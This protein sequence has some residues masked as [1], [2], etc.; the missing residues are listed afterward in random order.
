[1]SSAGLP[2]VASAPADLPLDGALRGAVRGR[3]LRPASVVLGAVLVA[4]VALRVAEVQLPPAVQL[5]PFALSLVVFGLPHGALDHLV[6]V[7]MRATARAPLSVFVVVVA[8]LVL[9]SA[10]AV[11]WWAAPLVGFAG[12]I[13]LT[14]FHWG[15]GD[16]WVRQSVET[17][18]ASVPLAVGTVVVRGG[19]PMLVPFVT[20]PAVY[21]QV[22]LDTAGVVRH[23]PPGDVAAVFQPTVRVAV[24]VVF[25]ATVLLTVL[26][27]ACSARAHPAQRRAFGRDLGA[28]LFLVAF[29]AVVPA[30]LAVGLYFCLWHALRHIVRL[31]LLDPASASDLRAG[32][33]VRPFLRFARDAWPV[34]AIAT[35]MLVALALLRRGEGSPLGVYLA[36]IAALT[37]PHVAVVAWMDRRQ[38]VWGVRRHRREA[39][40]VEG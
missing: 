24:G 20:Q 38:G 9:G 7:R 21:R 30:V 12:F 14:W 35:A 3:V 31:E 18:P 6:P 1:M 16:L 15:Q 36:L 28:T 17:R 13:A 10:T 8:Y 32:R 11:L 23:V 2:G 34:T 22:L 26:A 40:R 4:C 19:I 33:P 39:R 29:F 27:E 37:V 25:A 5:V